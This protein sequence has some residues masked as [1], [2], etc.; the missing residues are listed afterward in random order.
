MERQSNLTLVEAF[1]G[2]GSFYFSFLLKSYWCYQFSITRPCSDAGACLVHSGQLPPLGRAAAQLVGVK[3][4]AALAH[5]DP[6]ESTVTILSIATQM[7]PTGC[8]TNSVPLTLR[9]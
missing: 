1:E 9:T 3:G 5:L 8:S 6:R 4:D 2:E 7:L